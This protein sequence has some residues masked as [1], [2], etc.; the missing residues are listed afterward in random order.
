MIHIISGKQQPHKNLAYKRLPYFQI[1]ASEDKHVSS[2]HIALE[3]FSIIIYCQEFMMEN[4]KSNV[5]CEF[6]KCNSS[7][8]VWKKK[9][10]TLNLKP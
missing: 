3:A 5:E 7:K 9:E 4:S 1:W 6:V 8:H 2:A 10:H